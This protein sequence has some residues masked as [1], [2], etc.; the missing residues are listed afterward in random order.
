[1]FESIHHTENAIHELRNSQTIIFIVDLNF[2]RD[3]LYWKVCNCIWQPRFLL[4][5]SFSWEKKT[6]FVPFSHYYSFCDSVGYNSFRVHS[7]YS[8]FFSLSHR[9]KIFAITEHYW[10]RFLRQLI[11]SRDLHYEI[12][13]TGKI[14]LRADIN[15]SSFSTAQSQAF[16]VCVCFFCWNLLLC[17]KCNGMHSFERFDQ[18]SF[19]DSIVESISKGVTIIIITLLQ[20]RHNPQHLAIRYTIDICND[21]TVKKVVS[22]SDNCA[23]RSDHL[24]N[25]FDI[26]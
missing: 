6:V 12:R 23:T 7:K 5:P 18:N 4:F 14:K 13:H 25:A 10:N 26:L 3:L 9:N 19:V 20:C 2:I 21:F 24:F 8:S 1:M 16:C 11:D 15:I 22:F 17:H